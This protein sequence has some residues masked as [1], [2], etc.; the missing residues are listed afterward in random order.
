VSLNQHGLKLGQQ[1][2]S[3]ESPG[4]KSGNPLLLLLL[5]ATAADDVGKNHHVLMYSYIIHAIASLQSMLL[6]L[7]PPPL[8]LHSARSRRVHL[9]PTPPRTM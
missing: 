6:L 1:L 2:V 5:I 9:L 7:L 4:N 3:D 8:Q